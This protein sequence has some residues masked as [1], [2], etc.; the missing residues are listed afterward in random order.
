[1]FEVRVTCHTLEG[2]IN[3]LSI[4]KLFRMVTGFDLKE[5]KDAVFTMLGKGKWIEQDASPPNDGCYQRVPRMP[6]VY[7][8]DTFIRAMQVKIEFTNGGFTAEVVEVNG[9]GSK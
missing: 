9:Q 7:K 5:S 2:T 1:V 6:F 4:I 3:H 8:C